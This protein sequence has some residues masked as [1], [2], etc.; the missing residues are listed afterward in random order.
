VIKFTWFDVIGAAKTAPISRTLY[1]FGK[2]ARENWPK[3]AKL[4]YFR[5]SSACK[6]NFQ[7]KVGLLGAE[8][9]VMDVFASLLK[10]KAD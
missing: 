4:D 9:M 1:A 2:M 6:W 5:A 8:A 7:A 10:K 3:I